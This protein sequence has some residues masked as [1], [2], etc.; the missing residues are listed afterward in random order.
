MNQEPLSRR[1]ILA[2]CCI[3]MSTGSLLAVGQA[4]CLSQI[5]ADLG[6]QH[7]A[8][9]GFFLSIS[10]WGLALMTPA[11]AW[12]GVRLGLRLLLVSSA[13]LQISGL[14]L[15]A[16]TDQAGTAL[17]GG[18]LAGMGRGMVTAPL[19]ALLCAIY[20]EGRTWVTSL[21]HSFF[22]IGMTLSALLVLLLLQL[23]VGW[24]SIFQLL[25]AVVVS[26]GAVALFVRLPA[27]SMSEDR[28]TDLRE[29]AREPAFWL[30][31][32]S[33]F[34]CGATELGA[35]SWMP[36]FLSEAA[37]AG[38][39]VGALGLLLFGATMAVG[40]LTVAALVQRL[41]PRILLT[42][43]GLL[44]VVSLPLAALPVSAGFSIFWV[45][46]MGLGVSGIF[47]CILGAAGDRFP[48][49]TASLYATVLSAA[50]LGCVVGPWT[51]GLVADAA[52]LR[53]AVAGLAVAPVVFVVLMRRVLPR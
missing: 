31:L 17:A 6:M 14:Q 34:F 5:A 4:I 26:Y 48:Q 12:L 21:L 39:A 3:C 16:A 20:P 8:E 38:Q 40:R 23:D 32:G 24:R 11:S 9:K 22:H 25:G 50:L 2:L 13:V 29:L 19:S 27:A 15:I 51:M 28:G 45:T 10:Y 1:T 52:G 47:P 43:G 33:I 41:G 30:L 46:V 44:C 7:E 42:A 49:G 53:T 18:L 35:S 36:Y 37:G